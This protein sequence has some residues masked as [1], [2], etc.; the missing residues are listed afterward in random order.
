MVDPDTSWMKGVFEAMLRSNQIERALDIPP[1][2]VL[3]GY[4]R[5]L[6]SEEIKYRKELDAVG[7]DR[8]RMWYP[9][10][11]PRADPLKFQWTEVWIAEQERVLRENEQ[12]RV[13]RHEK[14]TRW[15]SSIAIVVSVVSCIVAAGGWLYPHVPGPPPGSSRK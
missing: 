15:I 9:R 4:G 7:I 11:D 3:D 2:P 13:G 12:R 8:V 6:K 1:P 14:I 10:L 5:D